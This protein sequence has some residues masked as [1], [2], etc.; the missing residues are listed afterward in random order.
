MWK[1]YSQTKRNNI[2]RYKKIKDTLSSKENA[3][4]I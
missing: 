1:A 4:S 3:I 2:L